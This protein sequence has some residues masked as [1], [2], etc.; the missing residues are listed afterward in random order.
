[1]I[2]LVVF[3]K[4][5]IPGFAKTRIA[6]ACGIE[7]AG[8]IY[9]EL[10]EATARSVAGFPHY[11]AFTG[12]ESAGEL[13]AVFPDAHSYFPQ[14]DGDLGEKLHNSFKAMFAQ[15][16]EAVIAIG[17]D[18]P[19]LQE[20]HFRQAIDHLQQGADVVICPALDGGYTLIGCRPRALAVF[21][22]KSWGKQ[23]LLHET[24]RIVRNHGFSL[25]LLEQLQDIDTL[26]DYLQW[27]NK[28]RS[29]VCT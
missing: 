14:S 7:T 10:L 24:F 5:P 6:A 22:A 26:E 19:F 12:A 15:N 27:R 13:M 8:R 3:A 9:R 11:I 28:G 17:C 23:D 18:C 25:K 20:R 16:A 1:M 4:V 29:P 2:P 21:Q